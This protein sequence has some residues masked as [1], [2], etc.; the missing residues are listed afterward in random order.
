MPSPELALLGMISLPEFCLER[1]DRIQEGP[2]NREKKEWHH[3]K[4]KW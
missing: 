2:I 1:R 4:A 3:R